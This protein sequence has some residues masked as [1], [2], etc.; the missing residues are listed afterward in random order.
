MSSVAVQTLKKA[1]AM[2]GTDSRCFM[3][4]YWHPSLEVVGLEVEPTQASREIR[5][6]CSHGMLLDAFAKG[7]STEKRISG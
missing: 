3:Y 2:H 4:I 7:F 6:S 5:S 1:A